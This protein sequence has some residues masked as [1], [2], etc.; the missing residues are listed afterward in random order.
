MSL[1]PDPGEMSW[2]RWSARVYED[3]CGAGVPMPVPELRWK[4]W[5]HSLRNTNAAINAGVVPMP[6][7]F[8]DWRDWARR[9]RVLPSP[10]GA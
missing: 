1:L 5:A 4:D 8:S 2:D 10:P 9:V 6:L 3:Y 7:G